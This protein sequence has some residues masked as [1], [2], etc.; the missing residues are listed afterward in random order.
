MIDIFLDV[1]ILTLLVSFPGLLR[2]SS[3][4]PITSSF[5]N[6]DKVAIVSTRPNLRYIRQIETDED[7]QEGKLNL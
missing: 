3:D 4:S 1:E 5:D 6:T 7:I 2:Y